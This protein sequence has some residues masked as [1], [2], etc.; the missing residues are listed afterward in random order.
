[1]T[2]TIY[3]RAKRTLWQWAL[4]PIV[5]SVGEE[6]L[7]YL[8]DAALKDLFDIVRILE[9]QNT[10]GILI[11]AGCALGGSAI[12]IATAKSKTRPLYV[13]DVFGLIPEPSAQDGEDVHQR[14]EVIRNGQA[15]GIAGN[16]YYGYQDDLF[17]VAIE[18]FRRHGVPVE[19]NAVRLVKGLFQDTLRVEE[20]VAM[21]HLDG[22]W[23]ESV[24]TCLRR[25]EPWLVQDGVLI[26]DDYDH[27]S[28][29]RKAVDEYF[30][31]KLG[32]YE[33]VRLSRLHII[34]K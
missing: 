29:S 7:S 8:D 5:R 4:P 10:K 33:F 17:N 12:V 14:Y 19:A 26:I 25:I 24:V 30:R 21:A 6:S 13:Y 9:R 22:D 34:R 15:Q 18:N 28:G 27:W 20:P 23:Y 1:M 11:E 2:K 16:T 3:E 31:D 32:K